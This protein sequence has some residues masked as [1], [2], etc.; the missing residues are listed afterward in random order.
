MLARDG[1]ASRTRQLELSPKRATLDRAALAR[2]VPHPASGSHPIGSLWRKAEAG[3]SEFL[4]VFLP[5]TLDEAYRRPP[6]PDFKMSGEE[7]KLAELH[8]LDFEH[9]P[10]KNIAARER[11]IFCTGISADA[12]GGVHFTGA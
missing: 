11:G 12:V 1:Q 7:G 5:W 9:L 2:W 10:S 3:E 8:G 6:G 4:P